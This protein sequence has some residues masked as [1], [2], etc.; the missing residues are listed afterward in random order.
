MWYIT[1]DTAKYF[2]F[3][4]MGQF[5]SDKDH[6]VWYKLESYILEENLKPIM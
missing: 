6:L 2:H 3:C 4:L 5:I 1:L